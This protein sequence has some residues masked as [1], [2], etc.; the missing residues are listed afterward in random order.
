MKTQSSAYFCSRLESSFPQPEYINDTGGQG[1]L[2]RL[3]FDSGLLLCLLGLWLRLWLRW[4]W[5]QCGCRRVANRCQRGRR[6]ACL[7]CGNAAAHPLRV[8][9]LGPIFIPFQ[10][11]SSTWSLHIDQQGIRC[12]RAL[13]WEANPWATSIHHRE[14]TPSMHSCSRVHIC[15]PMGTDRELIHHTPAFGLDEAQLTRKVGR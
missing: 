13:L 15:M 9:R 3:H 2:F 8:P 10:S 4:L 11:V 1:I 14:S 7:W 6:N 12:P 5:W